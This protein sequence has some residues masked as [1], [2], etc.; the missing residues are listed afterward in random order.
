MRWKNL[1]QCVQCVGNVGK[2]LENVGRFPSASVNKYSGKGRDNRDKGAYKLSVSVKWRFANPLPQNIRIVADFWKLFLSGYFLRSS[3]RSCWF[4]ALPEPCVYARIMYLFFG[5]SMVRKLAVQN[6][7]IVWKLWRFGF[8]VISLSWS[9]GFCW[10]FGTWNCISYVSAMNI[11]FRRSAV[12]I[13]FWSAVSGMV[14][15]VRRVV[16]SA[17]FRLYSCSWSEDDTIT[18]FRYGSAVYALFALY[19]PVSGVFSVPAYMYTG[20]INVPKIGI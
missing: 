6:F 3:G 4:P 2:M 7:G 14:S 17:C 12:S 19:L 5:F 10:F 11:Y 13:V 9:D 20:L 1:L 16:R 18:R 8:D 15:S